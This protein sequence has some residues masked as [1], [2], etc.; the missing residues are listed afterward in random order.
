VGLSAAC[1]GTS[2]RLTELWNSLFNLTSSLHLQQINFTT[3]ATRIAPPPPSPTL[4]TLPTE[5]RLKILKYAFYLILRL[6]YARCFWVLLLLVT[7]TLCI[8]VCG[9]LS[10]CSSPPTLRPC[11]LRCLVCNVHDPNECWSNVYRTTITSLCHS[12][13]RTPSCGTKAISATHLS[14]VSLVL[15]WGQHT[16]C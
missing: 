9:F 5:L 12:A 2:E 16:S 7:F 3:M 1:S 10:Y 15:R 6:F 11:I 8:S 13:K 14:K 4:L